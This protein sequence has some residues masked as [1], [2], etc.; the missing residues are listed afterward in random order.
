[1]N[2]EKLAMRRRSTFLIDVLAR[3]WA[4]ERTVVGVGVFG[5]VL[6]FVAFNQTLLPGILVPVA[7]GLGL[8]LLFVRS[9]KVWDVYEWH[10]R[11]RLLLRPRQPGPEFLALERIALALASRHTTEARALLDQLQPSSPSA[12]VAVASLR[13]TADLIDKKIPDLRPVRDAIGLFDKDD[14]RY[15]GLMVQRAGLEAGVASLRHEDWRR[16]LVECRREL[17]LRLNLW[18]ALWPT[19]WILITAGLALV[20]AIVMY[21]QYRIV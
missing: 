2:S 11:A 5:S 6:W 4:L 14:V 13:A 3:S 19:R 7:A 16:P 8:P 9:W 15:P 12:S 20:V 21:Y 10:I 17:G 18:R 1:M